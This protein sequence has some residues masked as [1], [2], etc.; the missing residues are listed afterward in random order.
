MYFTNSCNVFTFYPY[1][2]SIDVG[3][4]QTLYLQR[5]RGEGACYE[6]FEVDLAPT[7]IPGR[8]PQDVR[9]TSLVAKV[10]MPFYEPTAKDTSQMQNIFQNEMALY[11]GPLKAL[12]GSLVPRLHGGWRTE[13]GSFLM[14]M[15]D[16]GEPPSKEKRTDE[17]FR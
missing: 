15:E 6:T 10:H 12:Q 8:V 16:A 2:E 4:N 13:A 3:P 14:L 7:V 1:K 5:M 9:S 11:E 17:D